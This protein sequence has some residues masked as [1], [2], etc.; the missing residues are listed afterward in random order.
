MEHWVDTFFMMLK[1]EQFEKTWHCDSD[2]RRVH[3]KKR[4]RNAIMDSIRRCDL[5]PPQEETPP[6]EQG[7]VDMA[8][9]R[10]TVMALSGNH[11]AEARLYQA[12]RRSQMRPYPGP[13][14]GITMTA[15]QYQVGETHQIW[16]NVEVWVPTKP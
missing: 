15:L 10:D 11:A 2:G 3:T 6:D 13:R 9:F 16:G 14:L 4:K 8:S 7:M 5:H 1:M 12:D